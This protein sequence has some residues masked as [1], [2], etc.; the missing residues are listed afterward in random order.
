M[1][2]EVPASP[3][4]I[5]ECI[6]FRKWRE[7]QQETVDKIVNTDKEFII[8]NAPT[9]IGKSLI[10]VASALLM[11]AK[12]YIVTYTKQLQDQY[13]RDFK[14]IKTIKGRRNYPCLLFEG[15]TADSCIMKAR[16]P[17]PFANECPYNVAKTEAIRSRITIHNYAY[18]LN[19]MNYTK[20]WPE[21]DFL[22]L[23]E[24]HL[25]ENALMKFVEA[26]ISKRTLDRL[27]L[28]WP[29]PGTDIFDFL[30]E[31]ELT[32]DLKIESLRE[33]LAE[34][35]ED[36]NPDPT[37]VEEITKLIDEYERLH[38]KVHYIQAKVDETWVIEYTPTNISFR[39]TIVKDFADLLFH[40]KEKALLMSA[41]I[42]KK[43]AEVLGIENYLYIE[44]P[45][46]FP[47]E[48]R[49]LILYPVLNMSHRNIRY[50][51]PILVQLID[52]ILEH[53]SNEKG[54]IHTVSTEIARYIVDN[55]KHRER[56]IPAW[57]DLREGALEA[58]KASRNGVLVSPSMDVGVDFKYDEGRFQIIV[59]LPFPDYGD[60]QVQKRAQLD[61]DWYKTQMA[62]RLVQA[63]GRTNRAEDDYSVTYVFDSRLLWYIENEKE[64]FPDWFIKAIRVVRR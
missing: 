64:F 20:E 8:L 63:Y 40:H 46:P 29:E 41:T 38:R 47:V 33:E 50:A 34:L 1:K 2:T 32:L 43:N 48:R 31:L 35:T 13:L 37:A 7:H 61:P 62:N 60:P 23:D 54:I 28:P 51:L 59:K 45:S 10:A 17:C 49:P 27:N 30:R 42:T 3:F 12:T 24:A 18:Y 58:H 53:H 21:P 25:A 19:V 15:L 26:R 14:C 55:S 44:L 52:K 36:P 11:Q 56:L 16:I 6:P 22:V 4:L 57:G 39:P 9:G 5:S